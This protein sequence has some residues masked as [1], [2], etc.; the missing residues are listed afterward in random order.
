LVTVADNVATLFIIVAGTTAASD[1]ELTKAVVSAVLPI[2]TTDPDTKLAPV[3][4]SVNDAPPT[5][6][7]VGD[8]ALRAGLFTDSVCNPLLMPLGLVTSTE[9]G[10]ADVKAVAGTV[11]V[12][13]VELTH[14]ADC[15]TPLRL[16]V[17]PLTKFVPVKVNVN[18]EPPTDAVVGDMAVRV[19]G[20]IDTTFDVLLK[21]EP[22]YFGEKLL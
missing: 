22:I 17:A 18:A 3:N 19:G 4:V 11:V 15:A 10:P 8:I 12:N 20:F 14:V 16:T 21:Y 5:Y 6:A 13:F 2:F 1:V 7:M 9:I